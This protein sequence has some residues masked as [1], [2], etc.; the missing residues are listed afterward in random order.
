MTGYLHIFSICFQD[1]RFIR[2]QFFSDGTQGV[3]TFGSG[4]KL[5]SFEC[6][7][8]R[9]GDRFCVSHEVMETDDSV[10]ALELDSRWKMSGRGKNVTDALEGQLRIGPIAVTREFPK[11][12]LGVKLSSGFRAINGRGRPGRKGIL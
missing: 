5:R 2:L 9:A 3:R 6:E 1:S 4:E 11:G 12:I 7:F 10:G 8:C